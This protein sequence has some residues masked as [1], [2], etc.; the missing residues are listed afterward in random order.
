MLAMILPSLTCSN[1]SSK[2]HKSYLISAIEAAC[3][4]CWSLWVA[5]VRQ[6]IISYKSIEW[7]TYVHTHLM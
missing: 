6:N 1:P 5:L 3:A 2:L 7:D 4:G